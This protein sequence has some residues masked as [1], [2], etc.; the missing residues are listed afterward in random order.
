MKNKI[1]IISP[2]GNFYGSEQVLFDYLKSTE[3]RFKV[4]APQ[5]SKFL[6]ILKKLQDQHEVCN[7]KNVYFLYSRLFLEL[8]LGRISALYSNEGGHINWLLVLARIFPKANIIVHIRILEDIARIP[9]NLPSNIKIVTISNFMMELIDKRYCPILIYDPFTFSKIDGIRNRANKPLR[10]GIIGRISFNKGLNEIYNLVKSISIGDELNSKDVNFLFFGAESIDHKS[11][12]IINK[13]KELDKKICY[14]H[15]FVDNNEIYQNIDVVL[16]LAKKEPLG[17]IFFEALN[18]E[19]PIVGFKSGG[20]GELGK[21]TK[22]E[23]NLVNCE[24]DDWIQQIIEIIKNINYDYNGNIK[25]VS[26]SKESY[27]NY[28]SQ[29]IYTLKLNNTITNKN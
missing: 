8:L 5:R 24:N 21:I 12:S 2:S 26:N 6:S 28:F 11:Q 23:D 7:F 20:I 19:I 4:L 13:L 15:G 18:S 25:K 27:K 16:H 14:F 17:R 9:A 10:I 3:L 29:K 22:L 1:A